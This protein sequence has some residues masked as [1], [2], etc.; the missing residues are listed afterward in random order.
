MDIIQRQK[1]QELIKPQT[2]LEFRIVTHSDF[3]DGCNYGKPR[4]GHPEGQV[5]YHV[6][7][8]LE[9]VE[10]FYKD[11][12]DYESLRL[13]ALIHDS[14]KYKVD[15]T[16]PKCGE[17]HHG[18][19]ARRFA[20]YFVRNTKILNIIELHDEAYNSWCKG[21][22][23]GKWDKAE[24]R[25]KALIKKLES[26]NAMELYIKFYCC[27]NNTGDKSQNNYDW[28]VEQCKRCSSPTA[29]GVFLR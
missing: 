14:F 24:V 11:D 8:V 27:D 7:E 3:V 10:K 1:I 20:E 23:D 4:K 21:D 12:G 6:L 22:R 13:I 18:M 15:R 26:I 2:D 5:L 25:A 28:F 29:G 9:N 17:N 16:K 19:I